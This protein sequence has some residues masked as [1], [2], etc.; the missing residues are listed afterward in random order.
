[1]SETVTFADAI[2]S[3]ID[4]TLSRTYV[5]RPARVDAYDATKQTVDVTPA[6]KEVIEDDDGTRVV[7]L[8]VIAGVP[9][10]THGGGGF[11][12]SYPIAAGDFV[13][14]LFSDRSI[15][16]WWSAGGVVDPI[17]LRRHEIAD[18]VAITG[19]RPEPSVLTEAGAAKM[20]AGHEGGMQMSIDNAGAMVLAAVGAAVQA[21]ALA[22]AVKAELDLVKAD[23]DSLKTAINAHTHPTAA[24]GVPS[25]PTPPLVHVPHTPGTVGS[26]KVSVEE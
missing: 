8:P 19:L 20:I 21:I 23:F 5:S 3:A 6:L 1:M 16:R 10:L 15:D 22:D 26:T 2:R 17:D 18:A 4:T 14:L 11:F 25:I 24:I 12:T 13:M 7:D 9:V